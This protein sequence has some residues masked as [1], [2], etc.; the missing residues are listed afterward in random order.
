MRTLNL[1]I[2]AHVDAGK[3]SLTER[4][5]FDAGAIKKLGSVD[6]GNT[7]TDSLDLERQRGITIKAA[8]VSFSVGATTVN[9]VDTPGHPDFIAEVERTLAVL[10]AA[11]VVVSAVEGVQAQT[12]VLVRA[13]RRLRVPF[14]FFVNKV[15][16]LG[17]NY[18]GVVG[19]LAK[20]LDLKTLAMS[21]VID[22][23]AKTSAVA[24]VDFSRDPYRETLLDLLVEN[25]DVLL[26]DFVVE[27]SRVTEPRL[28]QALVDQVRQG[29]IYPVFAGSAATGVG[30]ATL[31]GAIGALLQGE[32]PDTSGPVSGRIFKIDRGWG[33]E[34]QAVLALTSGT[35]QLRQ[36]LV[37]P[38][39]VERVTAIHVYQSGKL[40]PA[41][42]LMAG[43]IGR[44]SGLG[45]A[46]IGDAVGQ[47]APLNPYAQFAPPTLETQI[48]AR[49]PPDR[50]ALWT[51]LE[52][53]AEQDPLIN[54]RQDEEAG[55]IFVSLYGEVQKEVIGTTLEQD[56]SLSVDFLE[57]TSICAERAIGIGE[58][59]EVAFEG[60]NPFVATVG[61]RVEP[62]PP[63]SGN[64]FAFGVNS[65]LMPAG[66]YR[67]VEE[68]VE[69]ALKLGRFGW[70]IIDCHVTMTL[71][72]QI[73][74]V[75]AAGDFR[76]L[77]PLVL[78][79]ALEMA[80]TVVCEPISMFRLDAPPEAIGTLLTLLGQVGASLTATEIEDKMATLKGTMPTGVVQRVQRQLPDLT[81]GA[82]TMETIF[83]HYASL[84]MPRHRQRIGANPFD[85]SEYL[86]KLRR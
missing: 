52:Q 79:S 1:G 11:V 22:Q 80:G 18:D 8:V 6:A 2:L 48:R 85:R 27:Q 20:Q 35:I 56:F 17:A 59:A 46:V 42:S 40:E 69:Q 62:R 32:V 45:S 67:A 44:V 78:A 82:A 54:L 41:N 63:G 29:F 28:R 72:G 53:L 70:P 3:T 9:L 33:G 14:L 12:R 21:R 34:K 38:K 31:T 65:G 83:D 25:D 43:Q 16:R 76:H 39:A 68:A 61:L 81:G 77:T 37:L 74:P 71:A 84:S 23:G 57:S 13:L 30:I 66:F 36:M 4:L 15:D 58:A 7:Q 86:A 47:Q 55:E 50:Q 64:S 51:A 24:A 75:S 60:D 73:S 10:D 49:R 26:D 5:L 19:S